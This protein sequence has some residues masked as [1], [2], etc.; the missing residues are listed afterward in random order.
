MSNAVSV[1]VANPAHGAVTQA[2]PGSSGTLA[3]RLERLVERA[4]GHQFRVDGVARARAVLDETTLERL[5]ALLL[6]DQSLAFLKSRAS[7]IEFIVDGHLPPHLLDEPAYKTQALF[8]QVIDYAQCK[9]CRLCIQV[10]PKHVYTDDGHGRPARDRRRAEEC[11]GPHQCRQCVDVCP[12]RTLSLEPADPVFAATVFVLLQGPTAEAS[13]A[14]LLPDFFVHNPLDVGGLL[15]LPGKLPVERLKECHRILAASQ[16]MPIL[17]TRGYPRHFVDSPDPD[18]DLSTWADENGHDAALAAAAVQ[19]VYGELPELGMLQQGKYRFDDVLHRVIDEIV[20]AGI[21]ARTAGGRELLAGI[22]ADAY[23][24][25]RFLGAKRRPIG[26]ILP[27]G[28]SVAWK[29]PYGEQIPVYMHLE[30][31]LGA[32]CGLCVTH[33]PEGG[34][35]ERSAIRMKFHVPQGTVPSLVRG[36]RVHLLRLDGSHRSAQ[37]LEDLT[38]RTPFDFEV[39]PDFCKACGICISCCPHDV[40]E[41]TQRSFDMRQIIT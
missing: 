10:C 38:G 2:F 22:L 17:E 8:T 31:C 16:F 25:E 32:E 1:R 41:P 21:D 24:E 19:L 15:A 34:G 20:N 33:C 14:H 36:F 28:T 18:R 5:E 7:R 11:T 26:G 12:E 29:T 13:A 4:R 9:A 23:V 30:K 3:E 27:P 35:G 39:D 6:D 40:I 37:D